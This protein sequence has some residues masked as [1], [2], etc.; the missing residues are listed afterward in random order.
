MNCEET[1]TCTT[2]PGAFAQILTNLIM[3]SLRHGFQGR[4]A[5][6]ITIT[7]IPQASQVILHY[8]DDG[9]GIVI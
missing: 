9:N 5:G 2:Y 8:Q 7:A 3:N 6:Q 1:I 4:S